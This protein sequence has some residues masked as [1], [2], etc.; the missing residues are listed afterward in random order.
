MH[1]RYKTETAYRY[2]VWKYFFASD[3]FS[4]FPS[5]FSSALCLTNFTDNQ[6]KISDF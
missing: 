3:L 5:N 2:F 1:V 6:W 4:A